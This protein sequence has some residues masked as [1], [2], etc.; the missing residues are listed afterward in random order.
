MRTSSTRSRSSRSSKGRKFLSCKRASSHHLQPRNFLSLLLLLLLFTSRE[1][2]NSR[3]WCLRPASPA[4]FGPGVSNRCSRTGGGAELSTGDP[5]LLCSALPP[6]ANDRR[7]AMWVCCRWGA[8]RFK[9]MNSRC[10][11][12]PVQASLAWRKV[13]WRKGHKKTDQRRGVR[14]LASLAGAVHG[15]C[16]LWQR[17]RSVCKEQP[18]SCLYFP[19]LSE[20]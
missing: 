17:K 20:M 18:L 15:V 3:T 2:N 5:A 16:T 19:V 8:R 1:V 9:C 4:S 10:M 12:A 7:A 11:E 13:V 14:Q 6:S